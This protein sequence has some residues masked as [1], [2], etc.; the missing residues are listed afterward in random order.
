MQNPKNGMEDGVMIFCPVSRGGI[1]EHA[2]YQARAL[3]SALSPP[4]DR[5]PSA[6]PRAGVVVLCNADF[7]DGRSFNYTVER[8][9]PKKIALFGYFAGK[10]GNLLDWS[11]KLLCDQWR[12]AWEVFKRKPKFVLLSTYAEYLS[13]LWIWPHWIF[14]KYFGVIYVAN[15]H[16]PVRDY[17][18]GPKWWHEMSVD[19]AYRHLAIC[20]VHQKLPEKSPIPDHVMVVEVP[21]GIFDLRESKM[22]SAAIRNK[23]QVPEGKEVLLSF[24]FIR[25]NKNLDLLIR[26]IVDN[27]QVFLVVAGQTQSHKDKPFEF[28]VEMAKKLG[29]QDRVCFSNGFVPDDELASYFVAA[30]VVVLT[31]SKTFHSQSGVLNLAARAKRPVLASA[32]EGP[33]KACVQRFKLGVFVEPDDLEALKYGIQK[34][35][36]GGWRVA[37]DDPDWAGYETYASWKENAARILGAVNDIKKACGTLKPS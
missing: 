7:L 27:S 13:P 34:V 37:G 23:W 11:L 28:Y 33:L 8:I 6:E 5:M 12:F 14:A 9:F 1:A 25:D 32:G 26:A 4:I 3:S 18:V 10:T 35:T 19:L 30:D 2:H 17:M 36:N 20:L 24:G 21:H 15:L 29:V 16:D 31:Y 22:D